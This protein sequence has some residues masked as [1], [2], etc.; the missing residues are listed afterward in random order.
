MTRTLIA[1]LLLGAAS[2]GPAIAGYS[3]NFEKLE[4]SKPAPAPVEARELPLVG[5]P[6]AKAASSAPPPTPAATPVVSAKSDTA[7]VASAPA[8][9][10][11]PT[12]EA[13]PDET[14]VMKPIEQWML[15]PADGTMRA[16]LGKWA[17]R[18]GWQLSWEAS[19]DV[20]LT[21]S[22]SFQGDFRSAVK[23]LFNSLSASEVNLTGLLYTGN[24]VLR[25]TEIGQRSQ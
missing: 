7:S 3:F 18:A 4:A 17:S 19:V 10:P 2:V 11:L 12:A 25:V 1:S 5:E 20:P 9:A 14:L 6:P 22:A 24:R 23:Q 16:V 21:V 15:S 13:K 8:A